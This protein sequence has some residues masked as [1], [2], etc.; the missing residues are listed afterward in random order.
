MSRK[1]L[2]I[3]GIVVIDVRLRRTDLPPEN[4]EAVYSRMK[5]EREREAKE[6]KPDPSKSEVEAA[7]AS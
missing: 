5:S 6:W 7:S 2:T 3:L 4:S 1:V